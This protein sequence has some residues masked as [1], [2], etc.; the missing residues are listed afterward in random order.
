MTTRFKQWGRRTLFLVGVTALTAGGV[1]VSASPA[2]ADPTPTPGPGC[3]KQDNAARFPKSAGT[4]I[5]W[6]SGE[7]WVAEGHTKGV[8]TLTKAVSVSNTWSAT[9]KVS[10]SSI[11]TTV[12]YQVQRQWTTNASYAYTQKKSG[13]YRVQAGIRQ[14]ITKFDVYETYL[15]VGKGK[16]WGKKVGTGKALKSM[17]LV[18]RAQVRQ[19]GKWVTVK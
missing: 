19:N 3:S 17:N 4:T 10:V 14:A 1:A 15:C 11:D 7:G 2:L 12:G 18:Y 13:H 16:V 8:L 6:G 5:T 9:V